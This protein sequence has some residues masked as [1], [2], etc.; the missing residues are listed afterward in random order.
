[1]SNSKANGKIKINGKDFRKAI[2]AANFATTADL[3]SQ[4]GLSYW[5]SRK[6]LQKSEDVVLTGDEIIKLIKAIQRG[7]TK[8]RLSKPMSYD[9]ALKHFRYVPESKELN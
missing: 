1:M 7:N 5:K 9:S 4:S 2:V 3:S 8:L 6:I